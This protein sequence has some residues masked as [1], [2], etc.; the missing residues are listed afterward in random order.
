[1]SL[2]IRD[3]LLAARLPAMPQVLLRLLDLCHKEEATLSEI[4]RIVAQDAGMT[5][6]ILCVANS[7]AFHRPGPALGLEQSLLILGIDALKALVIGESVAQVFNHFSRD[8]ST[9]LRPFWHHS[10]AT[11]VI[12]QE[13]AQHMGY[14]HGEEAYL[15]GLLHDVGRLALLS[16]APREYGPHFATADGDKLCSFEKASLALTHTEAGAWMIERWRLDSFLADSAL[17]HHEPPARLVATHPLVRIVL[18]ANRM[19]EYG[20]DN[21]LVE[22]ARS[23]CP[24]PPSAIARMCEQASQR[25]LDAARQLGIDLQPLPA[26]ADEPT[27][28]YHH[29]LAEEVQHLVLAREATRMLPR[30]NDDQEIL[31]CMVRSAQMLFGFDDALVLLFNAGAKRLEGR[32]LSHQNH[33]LGDIALPLAN[34]QA[35]TEAIRQRQP[36]FLE[37]STPKLSVAEGQLLRALGATH[38]VCLPLVTAQ[39][40]IGMLIGAFPSPRQEDLGHRRDFLNTFAGQCAHSLQVARAERQ[41]IDGELARQATAFSTAGRQLAHEANNPLAILQ[42]YLAILD[43]KL[44]R[45]EPIQSELSILRQEITRVGQII[46]R[47][48]QLTPATPEGLIDLKA[49][50]QDVQRLFSETAFLPEGLQLA[51]DIDAGESPRVAGAPDALRQILI[52]LIKNAVEAMPAGGAIRIQAPGL[53]NRNGRLY[54]EISIHDNGPGIPADALGK[55]FSS[56][57]SQKPGSYRGQGL[58]IVHDLV[59]QLG[60]EISCRSTPSAGT[61]FLVLLPVAGYQASLPD[62]EARP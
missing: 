28:D 44:A 52:N 23:L 30:C 25:T 22:E 54:A 31:D 36:T 13:L 20:P 18:L 10:L 46:G 29:Q 45:Q 9:D 53:T 37:A 24:I 1:M 6:R 12:A 50:I 16:I 47:F 40:T 43:G 2:D 61:R 39:T 48:A 21:P 19:A 58:S 32:P 41:R 57:V 33:H 15:A 17:Y 35:T 55:L 8:C 5:G 60:G 3:R 51:I 14:A 11:A 38:A 62:V 7:S 56:M 42:N 49:V 26:A 59:S 27:V 34:G 4:T